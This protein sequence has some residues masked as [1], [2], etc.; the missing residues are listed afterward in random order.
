MTDDANAPRLAE[1]MSKMPAEP[2]LPIE[3][4]LVVWSLVTG[5]VLL[6]VLLWTGNTFFPAGG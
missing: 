4:K 1:E 6:F 2:F 5:V 3:R